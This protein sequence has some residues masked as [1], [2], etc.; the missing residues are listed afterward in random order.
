METRTE[1]MERRILILYRQACRQGRTD[2]AEHL[3]CALETLDQSSGKY[4]FGNRQSGLA[5]AYRELTLPRRH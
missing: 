4:A 2:V 1:K 3:L 5:V